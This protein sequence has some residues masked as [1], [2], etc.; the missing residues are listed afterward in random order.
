MKTHE[1]EILIG[2]VKEAITA[3]GGKAAITM[4]AEYIWR[5]HETE[6]R[7]SGRL[8]YTWQYDMRW[9]AYR[10]RRSKV[11]RAEAQSPRG[12]WELNQT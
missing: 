7:Q 5:N 9:A 6:L 8:F 3:H 10:L 11:L 4:V 2:W 12:I 1:R